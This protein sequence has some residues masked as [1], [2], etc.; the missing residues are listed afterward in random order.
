MRTLST[1]TAAAA[2]LPAVLSTQIPISDGPSTQSKNPFTGDFNNYVDELMDEWKLAGMAV[3]VIDG[4]DTFT[5]VRTSHLTHTKSIMKH[6]LTKTPGIRTLQPPRH[7][8]HARNT[9]VRW[10]NNQSPA[11]G[12]ALPP[13]PHKCVPSPQRRLVHAYLLHHP[14]RLRPARRMGDGA[15]HA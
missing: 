11:R 13:H 10:I 9:L 6:T 7:K 3:A 14:G 12:L 15:S 1:L 5:H 4:D 8:S 2:I